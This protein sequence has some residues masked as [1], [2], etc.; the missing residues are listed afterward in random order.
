MSVLFGKQKPEPVMCIFPRTQDF[1]L[2]ELMNY[3]CWRRLTSFYVVSD[4]NLTTGARGT[5]VVDNMTANIQLRIQNVHFV[6]KRSCPFKIAQTFKYL[7]LH[8]LG[9][10]TVTIHVWRCVKDTHFMNDDPHVAEIRHG[11]WGQN[12]KV[13]NDDWVRIPWLGHMLVS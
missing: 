10:I 13:Q 6:W 5:G 2:F 12:Q 11:D 3:F 7:N 1:S 9:Q 8:F 4:L